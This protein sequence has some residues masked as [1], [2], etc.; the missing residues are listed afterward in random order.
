MTK[1]DEKIKKKMMEKYCLF[2]IHEVFK[3]FGAGDSLYLP[4]G[5]VI[6]PDSINPEHLGKFNDSQKMSIMRELI[7][8]M[9][10]CEIPYYM[11]SDIQSE[12]WKVFKPILESELNNFQENRSNSYIS[13]L[14]M[15][16]G[17]LQLFIS[18]PEDIEKLNVIEEFMKKNGNISLVR[19]KI[20][21]LFSIIIACAEDLAL[22][23]APEFF[24]L[25]DEKIKKIIPEFIT[26]S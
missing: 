12:Y 13:Y 19:D 17:Q 2:S 18:E 23:N 15:I 22:D 26:S 11:Y 8:N 1:I 6:D 20:K 14:D 9:V 10:G 3:R 24:K 5:A 25:L 16:I 21:Y 4:H 7:D